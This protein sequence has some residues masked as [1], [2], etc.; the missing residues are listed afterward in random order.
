MKRSPLYFVENVDRRNNVAYSWVLLVRVCLWARNNVTY[1]YEYYLCRCACELGYVMQDVS[2]F[3]LAVRLVFNA[4]SAFHPSGVGKWVP[5]SAEKAKAG[6]VHS[7]SG[8]TRSVQVK[9]WDPLRTRAIPE[10]LR[11]VI[12]I[13]TRAIQIQVYRHIAPPG[14]GALPFPLVPS[15]PRLL[16][17]FTFPFS[18]WL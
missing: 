6:V 5:A 3:F 11:G 15:L 1:S 13:T 7:V 4:N 17:F 18:R 2:I 10:D 16:L 12:I 8:W 14:A 9:L